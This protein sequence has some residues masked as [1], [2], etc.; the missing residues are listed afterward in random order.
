LFGA[1]G[2]LILLAKIR[3]AFWHCG[4]KPSGC[5]APERSEEDKMADLTVYDIV[6]TGLVPTYAA[7]ASTATIPMTADDRVMLHVKN[8]GGS[9][10]NI[11][12]TAK[13]TPQIIAGFGSKTIADE[14]I[15]VANASE[16]MIGP[17]TSGF[18]DST[19]GKVSVAASGT[20]SVT[21]AVFRMPK[22]A[23]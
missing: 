12:L 9:P 1:H 21:W 16:A 20:T 14:V 5:E 4:Q 15:A 6:R 7:A 22:P 3:Q 2:T 23:N 11:T 19:T 8:A 13:A 18:I 10:I 17:I